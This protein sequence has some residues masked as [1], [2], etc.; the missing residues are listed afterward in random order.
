ML[1]HES[2]PREQAIQGCSC[3]WPGI[4]NTDTLRGMPGQG[5]GNPH[6]ICTEPIPHSM[7]RGGMSLRSGLGLLLA[8]RKEL[9]LA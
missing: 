2:P 8:A 6:E 5:L 3:L 7:P 4:E 1:T 9:E